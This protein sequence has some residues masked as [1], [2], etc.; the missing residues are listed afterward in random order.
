MSLIR[1]FKIFIGVHIFSWWTK[2]FREK[3]T[4]RKGEGLKRQSRKRTSRKRTSQKTTSRTRKSWKRTSRTRKSWKRTSRTRTS[5]TRTS[6]TRTSRTRTSRTRTR[7]KRTSWTRRKRTSRAWKGKKA[8]GT[9]QEGNRR[10]N[11]NF[12]KIFNQGSRR[13]TPSKRTNRKWEGRRSTPAWG[14]FCCRGGYWNSPNCYGRRNPHGRRSWNVS[15]WTTGRRRWS[16]EHRPTR[17]TNGSRYFLQRA[18]EN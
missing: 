6:R 11:K 9:Q 17:A 3:R 13:K 10:Q 8:R 18:R 5:R 15:G 4:R 12:C 16:F 7:R 1:C 14:C 2:T